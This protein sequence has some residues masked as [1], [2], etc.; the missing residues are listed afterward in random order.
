MRRHRASLFGAFAV[1]L[2]AARFGSSDPAWPAIYRLR[3]AP[4]PELSG[5]PQVQVPHLA[6]RRNAAEV[7][8][9][10][11]KQTSPPSVVSTFKCRQL[12]KVIGA[13]RKARAAAHAGAWARSATRRCVARTSAN[14][15]LGVDTTLAP[16]VSLVSS[17][18]LQTESSVLVKTTMHKSCFMHK[19]R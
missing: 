8:S 15:Q 14:R 7:P 3:A 2:M 6:W 12:C 5:G 17:K 18:W 1:L 19:L 4:A 13:Q 11:R 16:C 9:P 10:P